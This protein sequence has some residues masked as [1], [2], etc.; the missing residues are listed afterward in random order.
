MNWTF[1]GE[2][3][4][5]IAKQMDKIDGENCCA[6]TENCTSWMFGDFLEIQF[7]GAFV[8]SRAVV[9]KHILI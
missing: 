3:Q 5:F 7:W 2:T 9:N 1:D 6:R 8:V 4:A